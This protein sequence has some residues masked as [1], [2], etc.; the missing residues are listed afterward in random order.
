[1]CRVDTRQVSEADVLG[2]PDHFEFGKVASKV[3]IQPEWFPK[4]IFLWEEMLSSRFA[5]DRDVRAFRRFLPGGQ[6]KAPLA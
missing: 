3:H 1:M 2:Y 4:R 6:H 5:D